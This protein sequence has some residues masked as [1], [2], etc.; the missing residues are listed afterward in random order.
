MSAAS[1][2]AQLMNSCPSKDALGSFAAGFFLFTAQV[3]EVRVWTQP[4]RLLCYKARSLYIQ[5][6][7]TYVGERYFETPMDWR[8]SGLSELPEDE[9][10]VEYVRG[11]QEELA[12]FY[13]TLKGLRGTENR[14]AILD[15]AA[16]IE[17]LLDKE[18]KAVDPDHSVSEKLESEAKERRLKRESE[19]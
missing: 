2:A 7:N 16:Q 15:L 3:R 1:A 10:K 8:D 12:R 17:T 6:S 11:A 5:T 9:R 18:L 19:N 4:V 14:E 13:Q